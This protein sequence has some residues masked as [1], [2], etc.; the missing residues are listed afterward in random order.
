MAD[1]M[2]FESTIA[3]TILIFVG[4]QDKSTAQ[5]LAMLK[6]TGVMKQGGNDSR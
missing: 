2:L 5:A 1:L 3:C 4:M 6:P